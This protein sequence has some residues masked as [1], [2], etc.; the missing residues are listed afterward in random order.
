MSFGELFQLSDHL[1][2]GAKID[3]GREQV[4]EQTHPRLLEPRALG[5]QPVTVADVDQHLPPEQ[6]EALT[7]QRHRGGWVTGPSCRSRRGSQAHNSQRVDAAR[8]DVQGVT[9]PLASEQIRLVQRPSKLGHLGLECV[10]AGA[11]RV[12][13]NVLDQPIGAHDPARIQRQP[14]EHLGGLALRQP[15]PHIVAGQLDRAK[16]GHRQHPSRV[17]A[18]PARRRRP[19]SGRQRSSAVV[20]GRQRFV[21]TKANTQTCPTTTTRPWSAS[22]SAVSTEP[23]TRSSN[24]ALSDNTPILLVAAA[25]LADEPDDLLSRAGKSAATARDRQLVVIA[26]AYLAGQHDRLDALVRDHLADHPGN[27]LAAWIAAQPARPV[28]PPA[29]T[30]GPHR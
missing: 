19:L 22:S 13:P 3:P 16:N 10:P 12:C 20:N 25:L 17:C 1:A 15:D 7:G 8:V 29:A 24:R 9:A 27:I 26:A 6:R 2:A 11:G 14:D 28:N 23:P 18:P 30:T 5:M 4:L 21:S